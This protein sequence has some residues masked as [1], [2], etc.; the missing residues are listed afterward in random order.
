MLFFA[1]SILDEISAVYVHSAVNIVLM[2][3]H[4]YLYHRILLHEFFHFGSLPLFDITVVS[5]LLPLC[6]PCSYDRTEG[7]SVYIPIQ[8]I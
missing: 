8:I 2:Y 1:F 5:F 7:V 6:R 4:L 3:L